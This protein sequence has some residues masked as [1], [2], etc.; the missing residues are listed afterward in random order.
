MTARAIA[1]LLARAAAGP[2]GLVIEGEA[3]IGKTTLLLSAVDLAREQ[4]FTVLSAHGALPEVSL[5]F[6]AV[7]DLLG[8]T[9]DARVADLPQPQR[10]A[11]ERVR[12]GVAAGPATAER[13][14]AAGFLTLVETTS[15]S[16]PVL[17]AVD[18]AQWLDPASRM[19]LAY[20]ARRVTGRVGLIVTARTGEPDT[21]PIAWLQLP[22]PDTLKRN[23]VRPMSLGAVHT[24]IAARLGH[25]LSRP[26]IVRIHRVS[27]GNPFFA[28]ELAR[29]VDEADDAF[30]TLPESLS[31]LV[32]ARTGEVDHD[33]AAILLVAA[34][35]VDPTTDLLAQVTGHPIERILE[36]LE[37][38]E[39]RG[40][41]T[42]RGLDVRFVHPLLAAGIVANSAA[43]A[44]RAAHRDLAAVVTQPELKARHLALGSTTGDPATLAALDAAA[45]TTRAQGAPATAAELLEIAIR[46]GGDKPIRRLLATDHHFAAGDAESALQ[47]LAPALATLD[48]GPM[49]SWAL[50]LQAGISTYSDGFGAREQYVT[51]A[52]EDAGS[53]PP[54]E[55][56]LHL[57]LAVCQLNSDRADA[58]AGTLEIALERAEH[59]GD[60][61]L[62]S[63]VLSYRAIVDGFRG[64]TVDPAIRSRALDLEVRS[65]DVQGPFRA[66]LMEVRFRY[67]EGDLDGAW[68][69]IER[70]WQECI[71]WGAEPD[72]LY[73]AT[74]RGLLAIWRGE[75]A[76]AAA[77]ADDA[78]ERAQ[79]LGGET[80]LAIAMSVQV[81]AAAYQGR[82]DDARR[83]GNLA[84][85]ISARNELWRAGDWPRSML[86]FLEVSL[87]RYPEALQYLEPRIAAVPDSPSTEI[88]MAGFVPD[89]VE[90]LTAVGRL[91]EVAPIFRGW[92][93]TAPDWIAPGCCAWHTE[94]GPQC[95]PPRAIW[96]PPKRRH[97]V[98]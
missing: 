11:I 87:G 70:E 17:L 59:L 12:T 73:V 43:A 4:G 42:V 48:R 81:A 33:V 14:A 35:A 65:P 13:V 44:Q 75:L 19:V 78:F 31:A 64:R 53:S 90:A 57:M 95:S 72:L 93:P 82:V 96:R 69:L 34:I 62:I 86:G 3:G 52:L 28:L 92:K 25:A 47:V 77:V 2:A 58:A 32:R 9:D 79:Q 37:P 20:A 45:A 49:R 23:V 84:L 7:A 50:A 15:Q 24:M 6:A 63:Q 18:D 22:R 91:D 85:E 26:N 56:A 74:H 94:V 89:V 88:D 39:T 36:L 68:A 38:A 29:T 67:W 80:A 51:E 83:Y 8:D 21:D 71:D 61:N 97:T 66:R 16:A 60:G 98:P 76:G 5:A 10:L 55:I 27:G 1:D 41:V 54:L 30:P 40:I 46:L